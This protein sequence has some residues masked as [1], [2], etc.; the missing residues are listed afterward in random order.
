MLT[1]I[2]KFFQS[3]IGLGVFFAILVLI[4]LGLAGGDVSGTFSGGVGRGERVALVG[5]D[6]ITVS[7]LT[8]STQ[9]TLRNIRTQ[10]PTITMQ[11]LVAEGA[12]DE[13]LS[14]LI[15]RYAIGAFAEKTGLRAGDNLVNSEILE[16]GAFKG[17]SGEFDQQ[18]FQQALARQ[19]IT[20]ATLRRDFA[21]GL[22]SRQILLPA[23]SAPQMPDKMARRYAALFFEQRTGQ[24]ALIRSDLF[25]AA[26]PPEAAAIESY[27]NDNRT[28][29]LL[30]ERRTLR[31][32]LLNA[33]NITQDVTPSEEEI[34]ARFERDEA[35]YAERESRDVTTF[36]VPTEDEAKALVAEIR[37]GKSIEQAA[38]DAG[39]N[40]SKV[41]DRDQEQYAASASFAAAQ[42]VFSAGQGEVIDPA[43]G[44]GIW[45]IA[46]VDKVTVTPAR[47]L[48]EV[49]A[50]IAQTLTADK[51]V[52]ALDELV[53]RVEEAVADGTSM[54]QL[55]Q[56]FDLTLEE[57]PDLLAD[58]RVFA[59]PLSQPN[60]ALRPI[61]D[62]AFGL[63]E[64]QPQ[65][66]VL[67]PGSQFLVYDVTSITPSAA[68][69][70][71]EIRERVTADLTRLNASVV[72]KEA[73]QRVLE[74][75]RGELTLAAAVQ[76]EETSLPAP[77]DVTLARAQ[78]QQL[79]AQGR[80]PPALA[81]MF[82]MA[83]GTVKL[84]EAPA[85]QGWILVKLD[86]ISTQEIP[87]ENP[88]IEQLTAELKESLGQEYEAQLIDAMRKDVSV[89]INDEALEAVRKQLAGEA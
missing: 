31:Y 66:D 18:A 84:L 32:A 86:D 80:V 45:Y 71:A 54:L 2:R 79:Q 51:R 25:N 63:E 76:E 3:K 6:E 49:S 1:S 44:T 82:S 53:D 36:S 87:E 41:E 61:L 70:L 11:T 60:P 50:E 19:G 24:I 83:E 72:A 9:S 52:D 65:L 34:A 35:L 20:E 43:Q 69:P 14:Q 62:T 46:R 56:E 8:E 5:D 40:T 77:D 37:A 15:D 12:L 13:L 81:L 67:V 88:V 42:A 47:T 38:R 22:L 75:S 55:A 4:A 29:Y 17:L 48:A 26:E 89:E 27:Y 28:D 10:D 68:P 21:D 58:G 59:N 74:R 85:N 57:A 39:Y 16:V 78:L 33:T 64:S 7:E 73:A 30:P 23:I